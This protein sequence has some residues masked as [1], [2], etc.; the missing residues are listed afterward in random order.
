M[1][2]ALPDK[3]LLDYSRFTLQVRCSCQTAIPCVEN[4]WGELSVVPPAPVSLSCKGV[5]QPPTLLCLFALKQARA[6][7]WLRYSQYAAAKAK[8][9]TQQLDLLRFLLEWVLAP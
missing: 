1:S 6:Q 3:L 8:L 5:L 2:G 7:L 9:T 4:G